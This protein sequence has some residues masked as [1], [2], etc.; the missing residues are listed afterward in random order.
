MTEDVSRSPSLTTSQLQ[1]LEHLKNWQEQDVTLKNYALTHGL[2]LSGLY[3]AKR[4]FKRRGIWRGREVSKGNRPKPKLVPV[5]VAQS[6]AMP[7]M[8]S[9]PAM[10]STFRV[11]LPNG[12]VVDMPEDAQPARCQALLNVLGATRP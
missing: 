9:V 2:S 3:T 5:R 7:S 11:H 6:P 12:I 8:P 4:V 10:P 1:W